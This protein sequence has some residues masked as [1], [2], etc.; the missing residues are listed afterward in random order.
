[1][2]NIDQMVQDEYALLDDRISNISSVSHEISNLFKSSFYVKSTLE[3]A[4]EFYNR[5]DYANA[6]KYLL[7]ALGSLI[8]INKQILEKYDVYINTIKESSGTQD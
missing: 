2:D 6:Y 4:Q 3:T 7:N 8:D 5:N 1:M